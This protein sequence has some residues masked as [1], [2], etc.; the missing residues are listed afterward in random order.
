VNLPDTARTVGWG[1]FCACSW[2]WCIGMFLPVLLIERFGWPGFIAFAIP[3][4]AGCAAFGYVLR[5]RDRSEAMVARHSR[6]AWWFSVVTIAFHVFFL[7]YLPLLVGPNGYSDVEPVLALPVIAMIIAVLMSR[8][9]DRG[10]LILSAIVY[11][12]SIAV[13]ARIGLEPLGS[14]EWSGAVPGVD[15]AWVAPVLVFGFVLCPYFDLTFHRALQR[16]PSRHAF[17]VFGIAFLVML[18]LTCAIWFGPES[19]LRLG[20]GHI[21]AQSFLTMALHLREL[22]TIDH[23]SAVRQ[24]L[25]GRL[26]PLLAII[27]GLGA[28]LSDQPLWFGESVYLRFLV[29]YGLVFPL[30][31]AAFMIPGVRVKRTRRSL[32]AFGVAAVAAAPCFELGFIHGVTWLLAPPMV[33]ILGWLIYRKARPGDGREMVHTGP[34][35]HE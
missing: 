24:R 30:Y 12:A 6:A 34:A 21:V 27:P 17:A 5:T 7:S 4:V 13:F 23:S 18:L 10:L 16:S 1:V 14:I 9:G 32:W 25:A 33:A 22:R 29:F 2:T 35:S 15:L 28:F 3:N 8:L 20:L 26:L 19:A 11:A 31:A